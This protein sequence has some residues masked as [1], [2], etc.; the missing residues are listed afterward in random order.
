MFVFDRVTGEP[1]HQ[2]EER[3][4]PP[5]RVPGEVAW[6]TQPFPVRPAP[7]SR[8][9]AVTEAELTN[10]TPESRAYCTA[11]FARLK[12]SDGIFTPADT[13]LGLWF[14]GTLGGATW[15][16]ISFDPTSGYAFVNVNEIGAI[17]M[18]RRSTD[19][20]GAPAYERWSPLGSYARFWDD[21]DLPCQRPPWGK[22]HAVN[23][24]TGDI[25]WTVPL[26]VND[27]LLAR[28]V[29]KT[30]APNIGGSIA[31][32]GGLVFIGSTND[33]RFR[34]FDVRTGEELWVTRLEGSGHATPITYRGARTG[35]QFVVIAA[36]GGGQF[37]RD[38]AD[39]VAAYALPDGASP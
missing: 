28:G 5:S 31:T 14:P 27:S 23:V 10:V 33:K 29:G 2:T 38:Q 18:M 37:D 9:N 3:P 39:V 4:V 26:G 22:L 24:A 8:Q 36:G 32:A 34:A 7:L 19:G 21:H 35:K 17:G 25:V 11:L 1:V 15:S 12:H 30:G 16:G 6:P 13:T 20:A